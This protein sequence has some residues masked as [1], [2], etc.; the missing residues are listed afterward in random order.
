MKKRYLLGVAIFLSLAITTGCG[1][2]TTE[3]NCKKA[4]TETGI[5]MNSEFKITFKND[6]IK[7]VTSKS[8]I[9]VTSEEYKENIDALYAALQEQFQDAKEDKGV[10]VKTT[11]TSDSVGI[12]ITVDA[13]TSPEQVST[14]GSSITNDMDYKS[15]KKTLE[16]LGYVCE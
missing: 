14:V 6:S 9:I 12:E 8:N 4:S 16:G 11:K 7:L 2:K 3:L 10:I 13:K 1:E 5:D 15:A